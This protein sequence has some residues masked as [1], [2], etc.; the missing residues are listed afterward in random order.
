MN[1]V[2]DAQVRLTMAV[3]YM[4]KDIPVQESSFFF[5]GTY[6]QEP[7]SRCRLILK[8]GMFQHHIES[9]RLLQSNSK[10]FLKHFSTYPQANS[11][12]DMTDSGPTPHSIL[13]SNICANIG[14]NA[15]NKT[16]ASTAL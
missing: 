7:C 5:C 3:I 9:E 13:E 14:G 1:S 15:T 4:S 12:A 8:Q 2:R 6:F 16:Q 11:N 10:R